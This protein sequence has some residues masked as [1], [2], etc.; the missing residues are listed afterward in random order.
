MEM[1]M[2]NPGIYLPFWTW[3]VWGM[4]SGDF[5][6]VRHGDGGMGVRPAGKGIPPP[7]R[8]RHLNTFPGYGVF[9]FLRIPFCSH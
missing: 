9:L 7:L 5:A 8:A 1:G 3:G 2:K 4:G 6:A